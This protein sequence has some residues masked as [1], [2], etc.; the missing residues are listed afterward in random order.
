MVSLVFMTHHEN[1]NNVHVHVCH[2]QCC[3]SQWKLSILRV[4]E[5]FQMVLA[6]TL[7]MYMYMHMHMYTEQCCSQNVQMYMYAVS[8]L[9]QNF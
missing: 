2:T 4:A 5:T 9:F 7:C 3:I 6:A 8:V 1:P